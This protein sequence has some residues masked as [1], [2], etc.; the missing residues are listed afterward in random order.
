MD[1]FIRDNFTADTEVTDRLRLTTEATIRSNRFAKRTASNRERLRE[2]IEVM[3]HADKLDIAEDSI[4]SDD[5]VIAEFGECG[6]TY[7]VA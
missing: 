5:E 1:A 4:R 7:R 6:A 3:I 2:G